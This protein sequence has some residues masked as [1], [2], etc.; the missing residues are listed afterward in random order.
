MRILWNFNMK[1]SGFFVDLLFV[2]P[3]ERFEGE[4]WVKNVNPS[5]IKADYMR[6]PT[7]KDYRTASI[8]RLEA[9][10]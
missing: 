8:F 3:G 1:S 10:N 9:V 4:K 2:D 6:E 5:G 7:G